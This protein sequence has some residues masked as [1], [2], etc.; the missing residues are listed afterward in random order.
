ADA[1]LTKGTTQVVTAGKTGV[2]T[3]VYALVYIDGVAS[4]RTVVSNTV[5]TAPTTRVV[6]VGTKPVP[7]PAPIVVNPGSAQAI[8]QKMV[9]ARGWGNDQFACLVK[10]GSNEGGWR[11][12]A[13]NQS[14]GAY[15]TPRA[16]R[17]DKRVSPGSDWRTN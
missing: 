15:G 7:P 8:A 10:L 11:S 16:L 6:K 4:G 9:A 14:R 12:N 2:A 13:G 3:V 5:I 17:G 1:S